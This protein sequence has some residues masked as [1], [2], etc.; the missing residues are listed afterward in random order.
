MRRHGEKNGRGFGR[1][2]SLARK[3][4]VALL[5]ALLVLQSGPTQ[6]LAA[7]AEEAAERQ[8]LAELTGEGDTSGEAGAPAGDGEPTDEPI[9]DAAPEESTTAPSEA[10]EPA[11]DDAPSEEEVAATDEPSAAPTEEAPSEDVDPAPVAAA[12]DAD[13]VGPGAEL[14]DENGIVAVTLQGEAASSQGAALVALRDEAGVDQGTARDAAAIAFG[15][16]GVGDEPAVRDGERLPSGEGDQSSG[17]FVDTLQVRWITEDDDPDNNDP[18][19]LY[20][21]PSDNSDQSVRMRVSYALSGSYDY[22]PGEVTI[23]IPVNIFRDREGDFV[24]SMRLAVPENPSTTAAWNYQRVGDT[25][26]IT[27]TRQ[28]SAASQGYIEFAVEGITPREVVDMAPSGPF[29]AKIEVATETGNIIGATSNQIFAQVDTFAE[30]TSATKRAYEAPRIVTADSGEIPEGQLVEGEDRYV[31]VTW[32]MNGYINPNTNQTHTLELNDKKTDDYEGFILDASGGSQTSERHIQVY[33]DGYGIRTTRYTDVQTAYPLSQ[34][35]VGETYTFKNEVTYSL[36]ETDPEIGDPVTNR[37]DKQEVTTATDDASLRW[38]YRLPEVL[39]PAGHLM[40]YKY[41]NSNVPY[42]Y[43]PDGM[44]TVQPTYGTVYSDTPASGGAPYR[45]YYGDYPTA[46]NSIRDGEDQLVSYTLNTIGYLLPWTYVEGSVPTPEGGNPLGLL[47]NYCQKPVTMTTEDTGLSLASGEKLELGTDYVYTSVDFAATPV[48][49]KARAVNLNEDGSVSFESAHD[50]TVDYQ[51]DYNPENIPPVELQIKQGDSQQWETWATASWKTGSLVVTLSDGATQNS[52]VVSLPEDTTAVR[53]QV[54]SQNAAF[55]YFTR[56]N[57]TLLHEGALGG[58]TQEAFE[59]S[60]SPV[61]EVDNTATMVAT[62]YANANMDDPTTIATFEKVGTDR[63]M[64]YTTETRANIVKSGKQ[65]EDDT[66]AR[67]VT[68]HYEAEVSV[69]SFI[70]NRT[71]YE[72]AIEDGSLT[73]ERGGTWYDL[74]PKGMTPLLDTVELRDGDSVRQMYTIE[75]Y[76]GSGRTLLVVSA[77]LTPVTSVRDEGDI[78]YYEDVITIAFDATYSYESIEDYGRDPHNVIAYMSDNK[79]LGSVEQYRGEDD[80]SSGTNHVNTV[81]AFLDEEER[82]AMNDLDPDRAD[83]NT[84]Y[85]GTS[86]NVDVLESAQTSLTKR[87]MV[88]NDGRWSSGIEGYH[89][90]PKG[91][92]VPQEGE[93]RDVYVGGRYSYRLT[94]ASEIDTKTSSIILYDTLENFLPSQ[95]N[96]DPDDVKD[97]ESKNIWHGTFDGVDLSA[98]EAAGCAPVVYYSTIEDLKLDQFSPESPGGGSDP[99][100]DNLLFVDGK[101]NDA[102]W[103]PLTEDTDLSTVRAI[104]IDARNTP[105]GR[106]FVL[107]PEETVSVIMNMRAPSGKEA[108]ELVANDAHAYNN[109]HMQSNSD[110]ASTGEGGEHNFIHQEYTKVGLVAYELSVSKA[111]DDADNQDGKRPGSVTVSLYANG[112]PVAEAF[113]NYDWTGIDTSLALSEQNDWKGSFTNLPLYEDDGSKIVYSLVEDEV[114]G[115]VPDIRFDGD[116]SFTVTNRHEPEKVSISGTKTWVGDT[117]GA[118]PVSVKVDL[119]ADGEYLKSQTVR[120]DVDGNW[121]YAFT[122]LDKYKPVGQEIKYTVKEDV[123]SAPSYVPSV[124]GTDITNTY[125]PYGNLVITKLATGTTAAS[126]DKDF[127]FTLQFTRAGEDGQT[128]EPIFDSFDYVVYDANDAEVGKGT[129]ATNGT[130]TLRSGQRAEISEIPEY[131]HYEVTEADVPGFTQSSTGATGIIEPNE[132]QAAAFTNAYEAVGYV[133]LGARKTLTGRDLAARQFNFELVDQDGNVVRLASNAAVDSEGVDTDGNKVESAPVTF[134][135]L[136]YTQ[137]DHGKTFTYTIREYASAAPG[138]T[139]DTTTYIVTVKPTDNGDGTMSFDVRYADAEGNPVQPGDVDFENKYEAKGSLPL[140]ANKSIEGGSL[141]AGAF[142]FELGEVERADDGT[143]A[144][145]K[146]QD[147]VTNDEAGRVAFEPISYDQTDVGKSFIYAV[148][149]VAGNDDAVEYDGHWGYV[150]ATVSDNGNG[151]L[152][153]ATEFSGFEAPCVACG[154]TGKTSDEASCSDCGGAGVVS[155]TPDSIDFVNRYVDGGLD[156]KKTVTGDTADADPNQLFTFR[157]ELVNEEGQ[158]LEDITE[159]DVTFEELGAQGSG[160]TVIEAADNGAVAAAGSTSSGDSSGSEEAA[161]SKSWV[162][163]VLD[164]AGGALRWLFG[165]ETANAAEITAE[166]DEGTWSWTLDDTGHLSI[167]GTGIGWTTD[168]PSAVPWNEQ[169][170]EIKTVSFAEGATASNRLAHCFHSCRNLTEIDLGNLDTSTVTDMRG[171]FSGCS[172]LTSLDLSGLDTSK[173][174]NMREMF[175]GCSRLTSLDPSRLDTASVTEMSHMFSGCSGLTSL[176]LS[177]L[178]T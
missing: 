139:Y 171:M 99:V 33:E 98:L 7:V 177:G 114:E 30:L 66:D 91:Q 68:M 164:V 116:A 137:I 141:T 113:P 144:F 132:D 165:V 160:A 40:L 70:S 82:D 47:G 157:V 13:E 152:S 115:Y 151:T 93:G 174:A 17:S 120:A 2:G 100:E 45:G 150:R 59:D 31:L 145:I 173:V 11:S 29:E 76:K 172:G 9:A 54:T 38:T 143:V 127:T 108:E 146:L 22:K 166:G 90:A 178:D 49:K 72:Q 43:D 154:G 16:T 140:S 57:V 133:N 148:H 169:K 147:G 36:T 10:G 65:I 121:S 129:V 63:L 124:D 25:F 126:A 119:Y 39:E 102:V 89:D 75:N 85:A 170:E 62:S 23:T 74:L 44:E 122:G 142:T 14:L 4:L 153:V 111:W 21:C 161:E 175:N 94:M 53:T 28:M 61:V 135:A 79:E 32:Y 136:T 50:G 131:V 134:G 125:H 80:N 55:L 27:N 8:L 86:T 156:I 24:G 48:I 73:A 149:E 105:D 155:V 103:Q 52:S 12:E 46:L 138:Y 130:I 37:A 159:E 5:V 34:F 106:D 67:Q 35:K 104:A 117:E 26:I 109:V 41:G 3:A 112:K 158:P 42:A 15:V 176:D 19:Y 71:T 81:H 87:V 128:E 78:K 162:D 97:A 88:N 92:W 77:N 95:D 168:H 96:F 84:L 64:G 60:P 20:L 163:S 58:V 118:R 6:A 167:K 56:V 83:P 18:D 123:T 107:D 51:L 1:N 110:N 101:L 69:E